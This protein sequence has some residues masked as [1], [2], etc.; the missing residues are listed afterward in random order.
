MASSKDQQRET[1]NDTIKC[2]LCFE[3]FTE[4]KLLDCLHTFCKECLEKLCE[5]TGDRKTM[6]CPLCRHEF[7]IPK[8]GIDGIKHNFYMEMLLKEKEALCQACE[9]GDKATQRC[10]DCDQNLCT[11]CYRIH[12]NLKT[13][14]SHRSVDIGNEITGM[15]TQTFYCP[16]HSGEE[17]KFFCCQCEINICRDCKLTKHEGHKTED[18]DIIAENSKKALELKLENLVNLNDLLLSTANEDIMNVQKYLDGERENLIKAI[19]EQ[20][21]NIVERIRTIGG[22]MVSEVDAHFE[23]EKSYLDEKKSFIV[24]STVSLK[25]QCVYIQQVLK[26]GVLPDV[27]QANSSL[28]NLKMKELCSEQCAVNSYTLPV[29]VPSGFETQIPKIGDLDFIAVNLILKEKFRFNCDC[30]VNNVISDIFSSREG[31]Q[32]WILYQHI[33]YV[34]KQLR[35]ITGGL[36]SERGDLVS[37]VRGNINKILFKSS[38]EEVHFTKVQT[39]TSYEKQNKQQT[40]FVRPDIRA[41]TLNEEGEIMALLTKNRVE[42]IGSRGQTLKVVELNSV[43]SADKIAFGGNHVYCLDRSRHSIACFTKN[44]DFVRTV[45]PPKPCLNS[46]DPISICCDGKGNVFVC[47]YQNDRVCCLI[48]WQFITVIRG[49][50]RPVAVAADSQDRLWVGKQNGEIVIYEIKEKL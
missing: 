35:E 17:L 43:V 3:P 8:N 20:T 32:S 44:F 28:H 6:L 29:F 30:P 24:Q 15:Q 13:T 5:H 46:F 31:T 18:I 40:Q 39:W 42:T 21:N 14:R 48:G 25:R 37:V 22:K 16:R 1:E 49:I 23:K 9:N 34:P 27:T 12:Q 41:V 33:N 7:S 11:N 47:D 19:E 10:F 4:P 45:G 36:Y 26:H 2:P 38:G 50:H